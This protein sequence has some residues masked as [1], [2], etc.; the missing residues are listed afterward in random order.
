MSARVQWGASQQMARSRALLQ[1]CWLPGFICLRVHWN[2]LK[3]PIYSNDWTWIYWIY[4]DLLAWMGLVFFC[5]GFHFHTFTFKEASVPG[6]WA[7]E[8]VS[9]WPLENN[10]NNQIIPIFSLLNQDG[11]IKFYQLISC[12]LCQ[13]TCVDVTPENQAANWDRSMG[14]RWKWRRIVFLRWSPGCWEGTR[15][16]W[17]LVY[18]GPQVHLWQ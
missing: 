1:L 6:A 16:P 7:L 8:V 18:C 13:Q 10:Q 15:G 11:F 12:V 3:P 5:W 17:R 14:R 2:H 4:S 9:R